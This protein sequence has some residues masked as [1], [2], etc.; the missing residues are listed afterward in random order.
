[1]PRL[2]DTMEEGTISKWLKH[3]GDP[4]AVGEP[5]AEVETDK[6]NMEFNSDIAGVLLKIVVQEG[7]SAPLG[8]VIA[9]VGQAG[10]DVPGVNGQPSSESSAVPPSPPAERASTSTPHAESSS[11]A[12]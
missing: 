7:Q 10:E 1:M 5:I 11:Q 8:D 9:Y 6:A 4:V 2:S 12:P 3:E